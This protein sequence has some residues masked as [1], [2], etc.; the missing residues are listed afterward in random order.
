[1]VLGKGKQHEILVAACP[2]L[3][4]V[5]LGDSRAVGCFQL[6]VMILNAG[7]VEQEHFPTRRAVS[8]ALP[9]LTRAS[10]PLSQT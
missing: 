7:G 6:N 5:D 1:M 2:R 9:T 4:T 10:T 3:D 8:G